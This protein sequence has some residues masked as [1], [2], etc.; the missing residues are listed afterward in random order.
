M[1]ERRV[2]YILNKERIPFHFR[3]KSAEV[4]ET[5]ERGVWREKERGREE[6]ERER[7]QHLYQKLQSCRRRRRERERGGERE[8][9]GESRVLSHKSLQRKLTSKEKGNA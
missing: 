1:W 7:E 6:E 5:E 2:D 4:D 8:T 3:K 9:R